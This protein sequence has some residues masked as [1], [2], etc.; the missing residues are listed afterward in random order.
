MSAPGTKPRVALCM[1]YSL[2]QE[3]GTEALVRVLAENLQDT[4][5]IVLVTNDT[6]EGFISSGFARRV[7]HI[8]WDP[9]KLS[10]RTGG[11]LA[12]ELE[13]RGVELAHFHFGETFLWG[14]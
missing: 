11:R 3:G 8:P 12:S 4:F 14:N 6:A 5:D 9:T 13:R 1:E 10:R 2:H 7:E